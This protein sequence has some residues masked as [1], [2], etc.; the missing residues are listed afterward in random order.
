MNTPKLDAA[1]V[2]SPD[3]QAS[4]PPYVVVEHTA[5]WSLRV[6][7]ADWA[8]LLQHAAQGMSSL[9]VAELSAVPLT[10]QRTVSLAAFDAETLLVDWL[11]EL[12][13]WAETEMLVFTEFELQQLSATRLQ[14]VVRGGPVPELL[15]HIK[16]VT[17]HN[18]EIVQ[19]D[20]GMEVTLVFDV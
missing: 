20:A 4:S 17:Y 12:A 6:T 18:L 7:G 3:N 9:M 15:K 2:A 8:A 5:D 16:A 1:D 19:T 14:A 11:S 10:E 13:Y